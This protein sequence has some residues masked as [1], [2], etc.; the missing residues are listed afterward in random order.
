MGEWPDYYPESCPPSDAATPTGSCYRLVKKAQIAEQDLMSHLELH[1][2]G[3]RFQ[4]DKPWDD[5]ED[6]QRSGLSVHS[7]KEAA[8]RKRKSS[9]GMRRFK[10]AEGR[11]KGIGLMAE[12]PRV[13]GDDHHTWWCEDDVDLVPLFKVVE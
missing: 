4:G 11:I 13:S 1:L 2:K 10:I 9:G 7:S 3:I 5:S 6:C 12:T 8:D